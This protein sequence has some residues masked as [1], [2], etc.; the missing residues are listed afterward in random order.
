MADMPLPSS[1]ADL[2][3]PI[4]NRF[5]MRLDATFT[6]CEGTDTRVLMALRAGL[7]IEDLFRTWRTAR[8][9]ES[10][11]GR[12]LFHA[13]RMMAIKAAW[14]SNPELALAT[15]DV[16]SQG[17]S[18]EA[19]VRALLKPDLDAGRLDAADL[20]PIPNVPLKVFLSRDT[21]A[22]RITNACMTEQ[23]E[24]YGRYLTRVASGATRLLLV[25]SGWKGTSQ[26]LLEAAFPQF[27]WE[28][29][30]FGAI[31]R[32]SAGTHR[33]GLMH[34]L[35]FDAAQIDDT[36]PE[37]AL[38]VHRHLIE[39]LFEPGIPSTEAL[40][41]SDV[42]AVP[43]VDTLTAGERPDPWDEVY[44]G[45]RA[46]VAARAADPAA[47]ILADHESAMDRLGA[48]LK[49]PDPTLVP[50]FSG[51]AR[52]FDLGRDGAVSSV[53]PAQTRWVHD[54]AE[55]RIR[56][57]IW[58]TGQAALEYEGPAR[59]RRQ[60][61]I[62]RDMQRNPDD[63]YFAL[64]HAQAED[65]GTR[66]AI[67]TRTK[68]R[69]VLLRRAAESVAAQTHE[70]Y[71]WV[72][73][74]DGGAP[75]EVDRVIGESL[76]DPARITVCHNAE[77]LGMEAAS[78]VGIS[79][80]D[81]DYIVVHD[82]DDSW[83]PRF[84]ETTVAFLRR[85]AGVYKGVVTGTTYVSEEIAG[86]DVIEHGRKPY[87]SWVR[88]VQLAEM[89]AGNFFAPI[90]FLFRRDVHDAIGG[91][92]EALPVL[93]DWDFNLRFLRQADIGVLTEPLA[94]YHHRDRGD[95]AGSY[96]NSV[97]GGVDRHE[98]Y[99]SIVR[100]K[101][102]RL[103][104]ADPAWAP[105]AG[106]VAAG[107]FQGDL[108]TRLANTRD[109]LLGSQTE[110]TGEKRLNR[111]L[112]GAFAAAA[113]VLGR[114]LGPDA[115][116]DLP[117]DVASDAEAAAALEILAK[118]QDKMGLPRT[119]LP[120]VSDGEGRSGQRPPRPAKAEE[121]PSGPS[122]TWRAGAFRGGWVAVDSELSVYDAR[123]IELTL[124]IPKAA[125]QDPKTL[126]VFQD[127]TLLKEITLVRGKKNTVRIKPRGEA[128]YSHLKLVCDYPE[129][130]RGNDIRRLGFL[131]QNMQVI[132]PAPET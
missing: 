63:S 103:A 71:T 18:T 11:G 113:A 67:V 86:E 59:A 109:Q 39:S 115:P 75:D 91:F 27:A 5:L 41:D 34:G 128:R 61:E 3:G 8:G 17:G 19:L 122:V 60:A 70:D 99:T 106:L 132:D 72:V 119:K 44:R 112:R 89:A 42:D 88:N 53:L 46:H 74:N 116:S 102:Q 120:D 104:A 62:V 118:L 56:Q 117:A 93:G 123:E 28:G 51:K 110:L 124:S 101:Y 43:D 130:A 24:R 20:G 49:H 13:S 121:V 36:V 48:I 69:P 10:G 94:N 125:T 76:V 82:D 68:D 83:E 1:A 23:A 22:A 57:A 79:A 90:A 31:G 14:T 97:I 9:Q 25:D 87:M 35:M 107:F 32:A 21:A 129:A 33:P 127:E 105:L 95:A 2:L 65:P 77:S 6:A 73:V 108:R 64:R 30:Y 29:I 114:A 45:V 4:V 126:L 55:L 37:T 81:S 52:S 80:V 15:L 100:N 12:V 58:Q 131:C 96:S 7:R 78:N 111:Q 54:A 16:E 84:L 47:R 85:N 92:D 40:D 26:M 98:A 38:I 50:V 66:V